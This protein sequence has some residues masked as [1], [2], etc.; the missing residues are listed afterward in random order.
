MTEAL[1]AL[2]AI[3]EVSPE[4]M[5]GIPVFRGTRVPV[6]TLLDHLEAGDSLVEFL[7]DFPT[8]Q[9]DQ[10]VRFVELA[11][12][13]ALASL[14]TNPHRWVGHLVVLLASQR[15]RDLSVRWTERVPRAQPTAI[16]FGGEV[17]VGP[18][19]SCPQPT[20]ARCVRYHRH[21][22]RA[23]SRRGGA[24]GPRG[25]DPHRQCT[26]CDAGRKENT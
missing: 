18:Q 10:A 6:Q 13:A 20:V 3:V 26:P 17:R 19:E 21:D 24:H 7:A 14:H 11:G 22:A 12:K 4:I 25:S 23:A 16:A 8:V 15:P 1:T 2:Q 9:R 5:S